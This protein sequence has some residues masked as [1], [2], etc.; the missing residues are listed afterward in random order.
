MAKP[1]VQI[2]TFDPGAPFDAI[3]D[4]INNPGPSAVQPYVFIFFK[5]LYNVSYDS[6]IGLLRNFSEND[7]EI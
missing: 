5:A 3:T 4:E 6:P 7:A 2:I 1:S